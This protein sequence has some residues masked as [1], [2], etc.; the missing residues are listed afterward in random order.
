MPQRVSTDPVPGPG[1]APFLAAERGFVATLGGY[2]LELAGGTLTVHERLAVPRFNFVGELRATVERSTAFFEAAL[3]HY[4]QRAL[5]PSFRLARP[6]DDRL[7]SPLEK[8][9][10]RPA[11]ELRLFVA[12]ASSPAPPPR[13]FEVADASEGPALDQVVGFL[14]AERERLELRRSLE[15]AARYPHRGERLQPALATAGGQAVCA[16]LLY[17]RDAAAV[18]PALATQPTQR[19]RGAASQLVGYLRGRAREAG[20]ERLGLFATDPALAAPLARLGFTEER[21]WTVYELPPDA[22]LELPPMGPPAPPRWR[23]P[24]GGGAPP[25]S[26]AA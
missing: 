9:A 5:R 3:D 19:G 16:G 2:A 18:V 26:K 20:A 21:V 4:F 8:L 11:G 17:V 23:P 15:V 12:E 1:S 24:R 22:R 14:S 10:F 13:G 7:V 6:A 25:A